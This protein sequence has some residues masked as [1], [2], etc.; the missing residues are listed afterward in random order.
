MEFIIDTSLV[1]KIIDEDTEL[2][3]KLKEIDEFV[4]KAGK[5]FNET[6]NFIV[7]VYY[8]LFEDKS[9]NGLIVYGQITDSNQVFYNF[10][11]KENVLIFCKNPFVIN[12]FKSAFLNYSNNTKQPIFTFKFLLEST[13]FLPTNL[14][15]FGKNEESKLNNSIILIMIFFIPVVNIYFSLFKRFKYIS[16]DTLLL[17]T[18]TKEQAYL[19]SK[20]LILAGYKVSIKNN[21][22]FKVNFFNDEETSTS[23]KNEEEFTSNNWNNV[24][25]DINKIISLESDLIHNNSF[26]TLVNLDDKYNQGRFNILIDLC[27][28][29][30]ESPKIEKKAKYYDLL[31]NDSVLIIFKPDDITFQL[32]PPDLELMINKNIHIGF[33]NINNQMKMNYTIG[34]Q[35]NF[36]TS[37]FQQLINVQQCNIK[38]I[39]KKADVKIYDSDSIKLNT[40][41]FDNI[42]HTDN[43]LKLYII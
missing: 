16:T 31:D 37:F 11:Q 8:F 34:K 38:T 20:A 33:N 4:N 30:F 26:V 24:E 22:G 2:T 36:L 6:E 13:L 15:D 12:S 43:Y 14:F 42:D 27:C 19:Y 23:M 1:N 35:L 40:F 25:N 41:T 10:K 28:E 9:E 17:L 3:L 39:V 32:D 7:K 5:D 29:C 18:K 21:E